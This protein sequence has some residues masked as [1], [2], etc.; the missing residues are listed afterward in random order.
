[1]NVTFRLLVQETQRLARDPFL[2]DRF[3]DGVGGGEGDSFRQFDLARF[4]DRT[5]LRPLERLV[6]AAAVVAGGSTANQ[7]QTR[8]DLTTQAVGVVRAE[9]DSAVLEL[10]QSPS[11]E[12][13]E[14]NP[15]QMAK[16]MSNLLVDVPAEAP[17]LDA[18]QR[19]ALI[20]A[21]QSKLGKEAMAPILHRLLPKL[22]YVDF[23]K[24]L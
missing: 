19:Q 24:T 8:K 23:L 12:H 7:S 16:F 11:L 5:G 18:N 1:M 17:V 10:C 22:R 13:A 21:A 15:A 6:L 2:A 20:A 4:V 14:F 9:F 3:R